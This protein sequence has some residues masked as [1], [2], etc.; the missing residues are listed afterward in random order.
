MKEIRDGIKQ[1]VKKVLEEIK[2]N[3]KVD[4]SHEYKSLTDSLNKL[5]GILMDY[6]IDPMDFEF[7]MNLSSRLSKEAEEAR[8]IANLSL[9]E[10]DYKGYRNW[11]ESLKRLL[12]L[13]TWI[14]Y[15]INSMKK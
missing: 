3:R 13:Y 5:I 9:E 14:E 4:N 12:H 10:G 11:L 6:K 1:D 7:Y 15:S 8:N 2:L